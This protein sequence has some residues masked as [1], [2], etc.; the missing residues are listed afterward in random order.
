MIKIHI[1]IAMI[2]VFVTFNIRVETSPMQYYYEIWLLGSKG[3]MRV[4]SL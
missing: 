2:W 4:V 3:I 1:D